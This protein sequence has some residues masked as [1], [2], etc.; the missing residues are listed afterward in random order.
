L[1]TRIISISI[2]ICFSFIW[3]FVSSSHIHHWDITKFQVPM[4]HIRFPLI[5]ETIPIIKLQMWAGTL[6][7]WWLIDWSVE[8]MQSKTNSMS[9]GVRISILMFFLTLTVIEFLLN[10]PGWGR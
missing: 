5:L 8:A 10:P 2:T 3:L 4:T 6:L 1:L 9:M 7:V